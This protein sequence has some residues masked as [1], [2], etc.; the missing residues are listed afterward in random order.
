M[1]RITFLELES[2]QFVCSGVFSSVLILSV[3]MIVRHHAFVAFVP[4]DIIWN[5]AM[6]VSNDCRCH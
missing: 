1:S 5:Q 4:G 2:V 3:Q 6:V